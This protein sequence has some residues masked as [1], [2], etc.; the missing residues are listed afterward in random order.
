MIIEWLKVKVPP[1]KQEH[2]VQKDAEIWSAALSQYPGYIG[3]EVWVN[4]Q[5][6]TELVMVIYWESK[7]AWKAVPASVLE[8]T[9]RRFTQAMGESFPFVEE[10]EYLVLERQR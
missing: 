5:D 9:D 7:A 3:K 10:G 6:E 8:A 1:E 2:Y 4:P